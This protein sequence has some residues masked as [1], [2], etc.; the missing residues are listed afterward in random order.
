MAKGMDKLKVLFVAGLSDMPDGG[1]GGQVTASTTLFC[2]GIAEH[3]EMIPLS[4]TMRSL[5]PP[6]LLVRAAD[7]ARRVLN[8]SRQVR[9]VDAALIFCADG[10]SVVEKSV[11]CRIARRAGVGVLVR[12]SSGFI[13]KQCEASKLVRASMRAMLRNTH[14]VFSQGGVWNDFYGGFAESQGKLVEMRN[15]IVVPGV[16]ASRKDYG[17]APRI[18]FVGWVVRAKGVYDLLPGMS[19]IRKVFP[20][21]KLILAGGGDLVQFAQAAKTAGLADAVELRGWVPHQ[22][23]TDL[24]S[25]ADLFV[26]PSRAEGM[27]N[28]MLEAMAMGL[29]V[30]ATPVGGIPKVLRDGENG[31]LLEP[32][33]P[34]AMARKLIEILSKPE[35]AHRAG[36][37]A[38]ETILAEYDIER[39]WPVY[40]QAIR[41]AVA[42]ARGDTRGIQDGSATLSE[43]AAAAGRE[44]EQPPRG[45]AKGQQ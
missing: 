6:P 4:S 19:E 32:G 37:A 17:A 2:S 7:A 45:L 8:F 31:F 34:P 3:V 42:E 29:P 27:P 30:A 15:G 16:A 44:E 20:G 11:M 1:T 26:L 38:R 14:V 24:L 12:P 40:L 33:N 25:E 9:S 21:A 18:V 43:I 5:P 35:A 41:R 28:A 22:Q 13:P 39:V 23:V 10:F 36:Q